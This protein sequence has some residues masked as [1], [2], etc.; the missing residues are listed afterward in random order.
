MKSLIVKAIL[1]LIEELMWLSFLWGKFGLWSGYQFKLGITN[2]ILHL[3]NRY[4]TIGCYRIGNEQMLKPNIH[5]A[6][7]N[8]LA[9]A[10]PGNKFVEEDVGNLS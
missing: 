9:V 2:T 6:H 1:G 8:V 7:T 5:H 4:T 10:K 3:C